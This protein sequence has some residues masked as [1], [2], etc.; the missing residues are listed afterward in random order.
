MKMLIKN[1]RIIDPASNTDEVKDLLVTDGIIEKVSDREE[2]SN[3][4][5]CHV[6]ENI[7]PIQKQDLEKRFS[8]NGWYD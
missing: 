8:C 7:T 2:V 5:H 6:T 1:G 3:R 4:V